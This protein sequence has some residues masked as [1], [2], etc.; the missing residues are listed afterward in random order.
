MLI[1]LFIIVVLL[2]FLLEAAYRLLAFALLWI[3]PIFAALAAMQLSLA[4]QPDHPENVSVAFAA[5]AL[6]VRL[7]MSLV[8]MFAPQPP[9]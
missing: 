1:G 4:L 9:R 8:A 3:I 2:G 7:F 6:A 5:T